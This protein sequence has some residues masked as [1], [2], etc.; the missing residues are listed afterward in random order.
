[1]NTHYTATHMG[2]VSHSDIV[3]GYVQNVFSRVLCSLNIHFRQYLFSA[4]CSLVSK[5]LRVDRII[6]IPKPVKI[7]ATLG[8]KKRLKVL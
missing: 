7:D 4:V 3:V 5:V 6:N 8:E 1:M 2:S